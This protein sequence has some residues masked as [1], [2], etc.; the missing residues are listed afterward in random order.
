MGIFMNKRLIKFAAFIVLI[1]VFGIATY[2]YFFKS[3]IPYYQERM[4]KEPRPLLIKALQFCNASTFSEKKAL[5]LGAG[6]GNDTAWLL[7][8][9][10]TVWANDKEIESI[11]IL[12][13]REDIKSY[14]EQL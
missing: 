13:H 12:S 9:G 7:K 3:W 11:N 1:F 14:K 8:N 4:Y 2:K 10:W 6:S 5:D